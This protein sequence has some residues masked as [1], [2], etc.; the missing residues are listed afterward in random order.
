MPRE[1]EQL[2]QND[3]R[4]K[5]LHLGLSDS[6]TL[7]QAGC[8]VTSFSVLAYYYN[9]QITPDQ[10]NQMLINAN[11]FANQDLISSD[12]DLGKL[13]PDI[14]YL[15]TNHYENAPADL[16][17]LK[18]LV[19]DLTKCV[20]VEIDLGNGQVHFTPVLASDGSSVTIMN[21]WNGQDESLNTVYGDPETKI[22]KYIVYQGTVAQD[23]APDT[24]M[25]IEQKDYIKLMQKSEELDKI[26]QKLNFTQQDID[27][28]GF[29]DKVIQ[30][31]E[32]LQNAQI[33]TPTPPV[34]EPA[35]DANS[36]P[37]Q[38]LTPSQTTLLQK[39]LGLIGFK[40]GA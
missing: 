30:K 8:L 31:F 2:S 11:L 15:Q 26:G 22:L 21:V 34:A 12:D 20:I 5:D 23:P 28:L 35:S 32:D 1:L 16:S 19:S 36:L 7:G 33:S 18:D 6:V 10:M 37:Q 27:T 14:K 17:L 25:E 39:L 24:V 38:P 4:W 9:Q 13:F 40:L 29:S 3:P